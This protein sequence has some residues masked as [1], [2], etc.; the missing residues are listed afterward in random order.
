MKN[1]LE[2][3]IKTSS[4]LL[5]S[6]AC[7]KFVIDP[8]NSKNAS[9][10]VRD[11]LQILRVFSSSLLQTQNEYAKSFYYFIC[12]VWLFFSFILFATFLHSRVRFFF[13]CILPFH[14]DFYAY[15]YSMWGWFFLFAAFFQICQLLSS[16]WH[17]WTIWNGSHNTGWNVVIPTKWW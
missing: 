15:K 8:S 17:L 7:D 4:I 11:S 5:R 6:L 10:C 14:T 3:K 1:R 2:K 12:C 9:I 13:N 16:D